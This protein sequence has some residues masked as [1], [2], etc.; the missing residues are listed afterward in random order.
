MKKNVLE[1]LENA[2]RK[3]PEKLSFADTKVGYT[4]K[5]LLDVSRRI[6]S[7]VARGIEDQK[8]VLVYMDKGAKNIA[9]FFGAVYGGGFYVPIDHL[10]PVER[11]NLIIKCG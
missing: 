3:E 4:Y 2:A 11:I 1:Y 8:A 9:A 6:G 10:M 5:Q 7:E